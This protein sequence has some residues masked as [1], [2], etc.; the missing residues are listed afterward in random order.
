[1]ISVKRSFCG[2][3]RPVGWRGLVRGGNSADQHRS[4][5]QAG[6]DPGGAGQKAG[7]AGQQSYQMERQA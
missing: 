4:D 5:P 6:G 1:M 2:V 3:Y 7:S